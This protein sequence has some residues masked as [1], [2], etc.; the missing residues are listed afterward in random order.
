MISLERAKEIAESWKKRTSEERERIQ[1][2]A[3]QLRAEAANWEPFHHENFRRFHRDSQRHAFGFAAYAYD[4]KE[5]S[6]E[7][8]LA[9]KEW[10]V[11]EIEV[12]M[13]EELRSPAVRA[14]DRTC[15]HLDAVM[16]DPV[17]MANPEAVKAIKSWRAKVIAVALGYR[18]SD[19]VVPP[20]ATYAAYAIKQDR[21]KIASKKNANAREWVR[22][23][24]KNRT[25][26]GQPKAS[27]ARQY[28]QLVMQQFKIKVGADQIAREWLPKTGK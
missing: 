6:P 23:Q 4:V 10:A 27:F 16:Q 25:D 26:T 18:S 1:E 7:V 14:W 21:A 22:Q 17:V 15:K 5:A 3:E 8:A 13:L 24:W 20:A 19:E 28:A 11:P 12:A 2:I 9:S